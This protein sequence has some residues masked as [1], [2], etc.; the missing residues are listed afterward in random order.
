MLADP[1]ALADVL[2]GPGGVLAAVRPGTVVIDSSTVS[3]AAVLDAGR[4][5]AARGAALLDA[6]VFG[7][8]HEAERGDLGFMIGGD[9]AVFESVQDLFEGCLARSARYVG[10]QGSGSYAKLVVNLVIALEVEA[11]AEGMTLAA[12]AGLAPEAMYEILMASRA[13]AGI[14][15]MKG[16]PILRGDFAPFFPLKLMDKDVRLALETAQAAG[17][18][19]P[20]LAAARQVFAACLAAGQAEEDFSSL[21]RHH[22]R[23]AGVAV[24]GR[25]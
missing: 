1:Q 19:T 24:R 22:E 2:E 14:F 11:F 8:K 16:P 7:S 23:A 15:E 5:L 4:K 13:R 17:V 12:A 20:A 10:P 21:I 3:P 18:P 6:P 25:G 9:R